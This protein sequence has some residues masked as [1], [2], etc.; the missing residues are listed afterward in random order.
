[1]DVNKIKFEVIEDIDSTARIIAEAI[2]MAND[3][4]NS[5]DKQKRKKIQLNNWKKFKPNLILTDILVENEF[6]LF[7]F[8]K[9][10]MEIKSMVFLDLSNSDIIKEFK[11]DLE[12]NPEFRNMFEGKDNEN[13]NLKDGFTYIDHKIVNTNLSKFIIYKL[14]NTYI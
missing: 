14:T 7:D 3:F 8:L 12:K 6:H 2:I 11:R 9:S 4:V 10:D 1:M 13:N 5:E